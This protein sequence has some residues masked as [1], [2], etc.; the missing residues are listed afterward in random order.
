MQGLIDEDKVDSFNVPIYA[1]TPRD[2]IEVVGRN[3]CFSVETMEITDPMSK[4][5]GTIDVKGLIMHLRA[6]MEGIFTKHFGSEVIDEFFR[7]SFE[8]SAELSQSLESCYKQGTQLFV[9]LKRT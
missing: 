4:M 7:R 1:P 2:M 9:V 6:G 5:G 3:G 8:R